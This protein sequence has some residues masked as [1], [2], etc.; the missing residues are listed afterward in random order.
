[1]KLP[2]TKRQIRE[3]IERQT[4]NFLKKGGGVNQV[5]MGESARNVLER[6]NEPVCFDSPKVSRTLVNDVVNT[7]ES[8]K[9]K[10]EAPVK[11][12]TSSR[13]RC[14]VYDDFGEPLRWKWVDKKKQ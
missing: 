14:I 2:K 6:A 4:S 13:E 11:H 8:R 10:K 1:M 12:S 5:T 9:Q 3:E 7:I